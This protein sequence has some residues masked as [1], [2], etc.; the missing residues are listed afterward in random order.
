MTTWVKGGGRTLQIAAGEWQLAAVERQPG[1]NNRQDA[2][3][4][5]LRIYIEGDGRAYMTRSEPSRDPTPVNPVGLQL[6]MAEESAGRV[7]YLARPCQWIRVTG[8][9]DA[10]VWTTERFSQPIVD[11][12]VQAVGEVSGGAPV[13]LVGY[14]GGAWVALQVAARLENV[15]RVRTVAGNLLPG[16]VN[17]YHKVTAI[18][19][20]GYPAEGRLADMPV[21]HYIGMRDAVVP[22]GVVDAYKAEVGARRGRVVRVDA[23]HG[24]GWG[25]LKI[26]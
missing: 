3:S 20:A 8:C 11:A 16:W 2:A 21:V 7:V 17:A 25:G 12:Y 4:V 19:V 9:S 14:S 5:P 22:E 6:A 24:E 15:V 1:G 10:R 13:E 26:K 23:S 18:E